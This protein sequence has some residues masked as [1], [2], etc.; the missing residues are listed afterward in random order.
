M[1]IHNQRNI[2]YT[3]IVYNMHNNIVYNMHNKSY[4]QPTC[5][6][7]EALWVL[8]HVNIYFSKVN[9]KLWN[10]CH[11]NSICFMNLRD[12]LVR[13][14]GRRCKI[15]TS[16]CF[17]IL[18]VMSD[19][20]FSLSTAKICHPLINCTCTLSYLECCPYCLS[21]CN[22]VYNNSNSDAAAEGADT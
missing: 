17:G 13:V 22:R 14:K 12:C 1:V 15:M 21:S 16:I 18:L 4:T 20:A 8:L 3:Y 6:I 19:W 5:V 7:S 10:I 2:T 11:R 9:S